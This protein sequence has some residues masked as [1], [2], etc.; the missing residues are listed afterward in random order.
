MTQESLEPEAECAR[1]HGERRDRDLPYPLPPAPCAGPG[2]ESHDAARIADVVAVIQV[3][4]L[5][6]VEVHRALHEPEPQHPRVEVEVALR[7][8]RDRG[9]V[10]DAQDGCHALIK[11]LKALEALGA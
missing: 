6:I 3:I 8:A 11:A 10:M 1:K 5:R 7:I 2:E 9:D 4:G